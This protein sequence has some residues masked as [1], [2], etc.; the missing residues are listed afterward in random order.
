[1][2]H[3]FVRAVRA[4]LDTVAALLVLDDFIV[5]AKE[6][7]LEARARDVVARRLHLVDGRH[8]ED[9]DREKRKQY[10][11]SFEFHTHAHAG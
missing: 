9:G 6:T 1:V 4:V 5:G 8:S 2:A 3:E 7:L 11:G 10:K